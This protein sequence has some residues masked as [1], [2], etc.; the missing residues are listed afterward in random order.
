MYHSNMLSISNEWKRLISQSNNKVPD[1]KAYGF[2]NKMSMNV[3]VVY[4][5]I[6][7]DYQSVQEHL[8]IAPRQHKLFFNALSFIMDETI[9]FTTQN[10]TVFWSFL[11]GAEFQNY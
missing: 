9:N 5:V 7:Q 1:I 6:L 2:P 3:S 11:I 8:F 4:D 10:G